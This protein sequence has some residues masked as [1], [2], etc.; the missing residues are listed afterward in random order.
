MRAESGWPPA[1]R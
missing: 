1:R